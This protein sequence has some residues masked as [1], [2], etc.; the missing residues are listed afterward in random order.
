MT[1]LNKL[2]RSHLAAE[3]IDRVTGFGAPAAY[4]KQAIRNRLIEHRRLSAH[5]VDPGGC[6]PE[7]TH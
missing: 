2:D 5:D 3:A 6:S 7:L 1:V 4:A